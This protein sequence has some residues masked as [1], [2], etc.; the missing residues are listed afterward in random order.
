M[1]VINKTGKEHKRAQTITND[2]KPPAN[3]H[4][5]PANNHKPP[6]ND[7]KPPANHYKVPANDR[8]LPTNDYKQPHLHIKSKLKFRFFFP[9]ALITRTTSILKI[10]CNQ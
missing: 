4:K 5:P 10:I 2:H 6:A 3:D 8:K 1:Y 9:H 7:H